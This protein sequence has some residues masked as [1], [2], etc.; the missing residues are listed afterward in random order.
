L[1]KQQVVTLQAASKLYGFIP[2]I[3]L[4]LKRARDIVR[5]NVVIIGMAGGAIKMIIS[6]IFIATM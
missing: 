3:L 1:S 6:A 2:N 5:Q 4:I